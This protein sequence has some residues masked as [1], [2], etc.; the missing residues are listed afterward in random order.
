MA[1][2]TAGL[3]THG[4][5]GITG[6]SKWQSKS[7]RDEQIPLTTSALKSSQ[8]EDFLHRSSWFYLETGSY[9][10]RTLVTMPVYLLNVQCLPTCFFSLWIRA[11]VTVGFPGGAN[12]K[13]PTCRCRRHETQLWSLGKEDPLEEGMATHSSILAWGSPWTEETGGL[14][15]VS[16]R[17]RLNWSDW[18]HSV[19]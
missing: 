10:N 6:Y 17:V 3:F 8:R 9:K 19:H 2:P 4:F 15:S 12:D 16:Q 7:Q 13:E 18:A 5:S 14:Q 1:I 11:C